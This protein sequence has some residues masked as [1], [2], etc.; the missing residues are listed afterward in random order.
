MKFVVGSVI[1]TWLIL[2][3]LVAPCIAIVVRHLRS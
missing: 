2:D 3:Q 1:I